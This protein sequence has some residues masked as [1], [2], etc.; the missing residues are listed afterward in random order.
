MFLWRR[1]C[2]NRVAHAAGQVAARGCGAAWRRSRRRPE[3]PPPTRAANCEFATGRRAGFTALAAAGAFCSAPLDKL[4][5]RLCAAGQPASR[6]TSFAGRP[7]VVEGAKVWRP[8]D[9]PPPPPPQPRLLRPPPPTFMGQLE[10]LRR[11]VN[12]PNGLIEATRVH[13]AAR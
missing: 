2:S 1:S 3:Q 10:P 5:S 9:V 4:I 6:P 12:A 7:I 11:F 13:V 8:A